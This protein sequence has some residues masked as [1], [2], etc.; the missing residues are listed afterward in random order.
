MKI[1]TKLLIL[2]LCILL[3]ATIFVARRHKFSKDYGVYLGVTE[4]LEQFSDTQIVV[5]DAQYFSADEINSFVA[6]GHKVY[7]YINVGSLESFRDYYSRFDDLCLGDYEHWDEEKWM[8]VSS[9]KWQDFI[10]NEL[11]P[12]LIDKGISGFFV[13]NS[14]VYYQYQN[15]DIL[16]GLA[17]IMKG[18]KSYNKEIIINGGDV[19]MDAYTQKLG[20][21]D[22]VITGINQESVFSYIDWDNNSFETAEKS[23]REY[24]ENYLKK[25]SSLGADIFL[26]E[27]TTDSKLID[28]ITQYC[29]KQGYHFYISD[30]VELTY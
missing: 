12:S 3:V 13:D 9:P 16:S 23:D 8:D 11:A 17:T 19:F 7:S 22:D 27:Y 26:L 10:L 25:Y 4:N 24:F 5:V 18:L 15:D 2:L 6:D 1:T 30:S 20:S 21:W 29:K 14:D 28:E